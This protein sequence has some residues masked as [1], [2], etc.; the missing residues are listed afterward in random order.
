MNAWVCITVAMEPRP[1]V[2]PGLEEGEARERAEHST[3]HVGRR[4]DRAPA[5]RAPGS[6]LSCVNREAASA[7]TS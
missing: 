5:S 7:V 3:T 1:L 4:W 2:E 6:G